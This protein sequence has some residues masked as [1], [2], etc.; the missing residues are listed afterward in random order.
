MVIDAEAQMIGVP[1]EK[2]DGR[3]IIIKKRKRKQLL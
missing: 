2:K 1:E 3:E